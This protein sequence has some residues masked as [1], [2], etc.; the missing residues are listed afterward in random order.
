[1]WKAA[2][3]AV[4]PTQA[5]GNEAVLSGTSVLE[6]NAT[7]GSSARGEASGNS[8]TIKENSE[9]KGDAAGGDVYMG[10]ISKNIITIQYNA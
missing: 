9:V 3:L 8:L 2:C 5:D 6:G 7:G 10:T 4:T 1:M